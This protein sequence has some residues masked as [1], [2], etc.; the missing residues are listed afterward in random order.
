[1]QQL[2]PVEQLIAVAEA[3]YIQPGRELGQAELLAAGFG[4]GFEQQSAL[5]VV[6][7]HL[8]RRVEL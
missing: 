7:L 8:Q 2:S 4:L 5:Q 3:P 6:E 1:M